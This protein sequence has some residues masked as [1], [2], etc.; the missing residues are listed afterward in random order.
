MIAL[1]VWTKS[2]NSLSFDIEN[3]EDSQ[4][5]FSLLFVRR[6]TCQE[7]SIPVQ[8]IKLC[9]NRVRF[10]FSVDC[11]LLSGLH[12]LTITNTTKDEIILSDY[13]ANVYDVPRECVKNEI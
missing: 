9:D 5:S 1:N 12:D 3:F 2:P 6:R 8:E 7:V 13:P 10:C 11:E 4:D